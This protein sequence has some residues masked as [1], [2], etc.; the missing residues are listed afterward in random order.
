MFLKRVFPLST[1]G[2][3]GN[4]R[5]GLEQWPFK[6]VPSWSWPFHIAGSFRFSASSFWGRLSHPAKEE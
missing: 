4:Q 5:N 3:T 6:W 2:V 1:A